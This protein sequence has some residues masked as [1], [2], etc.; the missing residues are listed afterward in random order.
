MALSTKVVHEILSAFGCFWF[1]HD[2]YGFRLWRTE[3]RPFGGGP[4]PPPPPHEWRLS[5]GGGISGEG[6]RVWWLERNDGSE[7]SEKVTTRKDLRRIVR[8]WLAGP[9]EAGATFVKMH[10]TNAGAHYVWCR[11]APSQ[12]KE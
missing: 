9:R 7:K 8:E 4:T 12:N 6:D 1:A 3:C 5:R 11:R 10:R 2:G